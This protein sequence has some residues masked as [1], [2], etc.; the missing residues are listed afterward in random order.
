M[1]EGELVDEVKEFH[2]WTDLVTIGQTRDECAFFC[3]VWR[4]QTVSDLRDNLEHVFPDPSFRGEV[5]SAYSLTDAS[6]HAQLVEAHIQISTDCLFS[7]ATQRVAEANG[8]IWAYTFDQ[9]DWSDIDFIA[10]TAYHSL[11]NPFFFY[12]PAVTT[13]T[14]S[15]DIK[16]SA[17]VYA[18]A[19]VEVVNGN[20]PWEQ[21]GA[22]SRVMAIDGLKSGMQKKP[23]NERWRSLVSTKQREAMFSQG[24]A[25]L[26]EAMRKTAE[27]EAERVAKQQLRREK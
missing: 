5:L 22:N 18:T 27:E 23:F 12:L 15:R 24:R 11:D 17:R 26:M 16:E 2:P 6:T 8:K 9:C 14:E 19:C 20:A 3:G 10:G 13:K 1:H 7:L 21:Y 4:G 25:L